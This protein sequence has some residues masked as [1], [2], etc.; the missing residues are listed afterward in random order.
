MLPPRR[1]CPVGGSIYHFII[2]KATKLSAPLNLKEHVIKYEHSVQLPKWRVNDASIKEILDTG[3]QISA[4]TK[5]MT[6]SK[7]KPTVLQ[8]ISDVSGP[9]AGLSH[10][11][12]LHFN[13]LAV[14]PC[15]LAHICLYPCCHIAAVSLYVLSRIMVMNAIIFSPA[16]I[17]VP[18]ESPPIWLIN[19]LSSS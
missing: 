6:S 19:F 13:M 17:I 7:L 16:S 5:D 11:L 10:T 15:T 9:A 18:S 3:I 2:I 4:T 1:G 14:T 12:S 8:A